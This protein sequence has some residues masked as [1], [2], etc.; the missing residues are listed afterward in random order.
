MDSKRFLLVSTSK[1]SSYYIFSVASGKSTNKLLNITDLIGNCSSACVQ[2]V[3]WIITTKNV[4]IMNV[5]PKTLAAVLEPSTVNI[6]LVQ[7]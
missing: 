1:V 5:T 3:Y 6:D 2:E 4:F 7:G